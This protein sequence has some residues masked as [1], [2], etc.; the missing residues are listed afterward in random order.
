[1]IRNFILK[2]RTLS[3]SPL[4]D[5]IANINQYLY[6]H[7]IAT[8]LSRKGSRFSVSSMHL[9]CWNLYPVIKTHDSELQGQEEAGCT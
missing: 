1:M 6:N 9:T 3:C 2:F 5:Y 7:N 4:R 8:E